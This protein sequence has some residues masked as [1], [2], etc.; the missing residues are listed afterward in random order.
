M[1]PQNSYPVL[2]NFYQ[3]VRTQDEQQIVLQPGGASASH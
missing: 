3:I 1:V 2:R